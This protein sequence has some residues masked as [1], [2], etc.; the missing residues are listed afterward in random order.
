MVFQ[1]ESLKI[2]NNTQQF[3]GYGYGLYEFFLWI[4]QFFSILNINIDGKF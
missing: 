4:F 3:T 1:Y 2:F